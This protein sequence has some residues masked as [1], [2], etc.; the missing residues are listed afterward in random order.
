MEIICAF[1][2]ACNVIKAK[3]KRNAH[4]IVV[5]CTFFIVC[6]VITHI[7]LRALQLIKIHTIAHFTD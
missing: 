2:I 1:L 3:D 6:N 5:N 4:T 7:R